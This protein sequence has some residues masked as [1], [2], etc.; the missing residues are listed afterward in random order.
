MALAGEFL[1]REPAAAEALSLWRVPWKELIQ[2]LGRFVERGHGDGDGIGA[3]DVGHRVSEDLCGDQL[4]DEDAEDDD[5]DHDS[6]E[7]RLGRRVLHMWEVKDWAG[8]SY[9]SALKCF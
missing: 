9:I 5:D 3:D 6:V 2:D 4:A 1:H 7:R 8:Q